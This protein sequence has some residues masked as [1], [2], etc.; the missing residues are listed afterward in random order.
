VSLLAGAAKIEYADGRTLDLAAGDTLV[1]PPR[2]KHRVA[3]T[4]SEPPCVWLCVF[5]GKANA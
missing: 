1:I 2:E 3:Y 5:Y 4:S